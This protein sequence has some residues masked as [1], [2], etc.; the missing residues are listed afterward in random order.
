MTTLD[1]A[2]LG[3]SR[4]YKL[5]SALVVP[6]PIAW[7]GTMSADGVPNLAPFSF[8]NVVSNDPPTVMVSITNRPDGRDKDS[9]TNLDHDPG[10]TISLVSYPQFEQMWHSSLTHEPE[11]DEYAAAG[12]PT[13]PGDRVA[14]LRVA[15]APAAL[16]VTRTR[17]IEVGAYTLNLLRVLALHVRDD[18]IDERL[19]VDLAGLDAVGR[20]STRFI[21]VDD[22]FE[23]PN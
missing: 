10:A 17:R 2:D 20:L 13:E 9:L 16:E 21:R 12:L 1:P 14:A 3:P 5:L 11:V 15:D 19:H 8:F 7:L 4:T 22:I 6:R 18:L 23:P